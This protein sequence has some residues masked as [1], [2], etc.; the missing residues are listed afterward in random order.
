MV[1]YIARLPAP[2]AAVEVRVPTDRCTLPRVRRIAEF[3]YPETCTLGAI[4]YQFPDLDAAIRWVAGYCGPWGSRVRDL[5][6]ALREE[7]IP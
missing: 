5:L 4:T 2:P 3:E 7:E 6:Y 1:K